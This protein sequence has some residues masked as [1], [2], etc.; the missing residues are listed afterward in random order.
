MPFVISANPVH[1]KNTFLS[2]DFIPV[3]FF[4]LRID[5]LGIPAVKAGMLI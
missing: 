2:S 3:L 1:S 5:I 4:S